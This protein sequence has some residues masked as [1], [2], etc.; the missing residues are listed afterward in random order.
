MSIKQ[1]LSQLKTMDIYSLML[2][3]LFKIKDV[4]EYSA[5]SEL[6]YVL[7]KDNF[8]KLCEYF[9][10]LTITIPT[11][12]ELQE[13]VYALVLY[14]YV[15]IENIPMESAIKMIKHSSNETYVIKNNYYKIKEVLQ[16]Y[17][18]FPRQKDN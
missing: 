16:G 10:G 18:F 12:D 7:D 4:P 14:Q 9:G 17:E 15:D 11:V 3:A 5:L 2:F 1:A 13:I 8:L 6:A